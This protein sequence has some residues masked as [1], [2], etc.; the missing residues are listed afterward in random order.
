MT[1]T[2]ATT[3]ECIE[4]LVCLQNNRE[5][6]YWDDELRRLRCAEEQDKS[7]T[8]LM[9]EATRTLGIKNRGEY[10]KIK[11]KYNLTQY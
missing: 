3:L 1:G 9:E 4:E 8:P 6:I 10:T 11:K 5:N 2:D 7:W